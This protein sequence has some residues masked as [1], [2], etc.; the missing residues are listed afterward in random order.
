MVYGEVERQDDSVVFVNYQSAL[1]G[2]R[3]RARTMRNDRVREEV[4]NHG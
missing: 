4:P 2:G 1:V 3:R